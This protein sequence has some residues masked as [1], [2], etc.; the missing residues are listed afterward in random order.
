MFRFQ[1]I[2]DGGGAFN[3]GDAVHQLVRHL[4]VLVVVLEEAVG[5]SAAAAD[6]TAAAVAVS[7][8]CVEGS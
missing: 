8:A 4:L 6:A 2:A 5:A 3:F 1:R 7:G